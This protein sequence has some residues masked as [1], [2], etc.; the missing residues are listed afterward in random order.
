MK[1]IK[2]KALKVFARAFKNCIVEIAPLTTLN[3]RIVISFSLKE[4][5]K[6]YNYNFYFF[7]IKK[8]VSFNVNENTSQN[9]I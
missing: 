5:A 6:S 4:L 8:V 2:Q 7:P 9:H 1:V 3:S